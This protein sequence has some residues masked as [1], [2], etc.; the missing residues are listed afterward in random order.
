MI[1]QVNPSSS[2]FFKSDPSKQWI[3][4]DLFKF[5]NLTDSCLLLGFLP[6]S[7]ESFSAFNLALSYRKIITVIIPSWKKL[8]SWKRFNFRTPG[9]GWEPASA[10]K[11]IIILNRS[12]RA[13]VPRKARSSQPTRRP[14]RA[15]PPSSASTSSKWPRWGEELAEWRI[16]LFIPCLSRQNDEKEKKNAE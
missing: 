11:T 16:C 1:G 7:A 6:M 12:A 5:L 9:P 4:N 2:F 13:S 3:M 8:F 10:Y 15:S 14:S